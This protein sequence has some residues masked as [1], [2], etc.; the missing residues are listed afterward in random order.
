[1]VKACFPSPISSF[2]LAVSLAGCNAER[3][4]SNPSS[5][6]KQEV[7]RLRST[8]PAH[9]PVIFGRVQAVD[10]VGPHPMSKALVSVDG[11]P[12]YTNERGAY[13]VTVTPGT[14]QLLVEHIG[15]R[16]TLTTVKTE[17]GDSLMVNFYPRYT[18]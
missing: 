3:V 17:R 6:R 18:D 12:Y 5:L 16:Q 1:M 14:H 9:A 2:L 7:V 11:Q 15:V 10:D 4:T 13:R 8:N